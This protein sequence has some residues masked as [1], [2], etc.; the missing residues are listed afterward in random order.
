MSTPLRFL[1]VSDT[2]ITAKHV[3][4]ICLV[5]R[6]WKSPRR[7]VIRSLQQL[8]ENG[9]YPVGIVSNFMKIRKGLGQY[10]YYYSYSSSGYR[11]YS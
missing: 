7:A 9:T 5:F 3:D 2:L 11:S 10:G 8:T 4:A 6:M 1:A